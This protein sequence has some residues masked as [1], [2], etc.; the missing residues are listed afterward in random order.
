MPSIHGLATGRY[1]QR[2]KF[3]EDGLHSTLG[4]TEKFRAADAGE[5]PAHALENRLA[6]HV[7]G[8]LF[9]RAVTVTIALDG[10]TFAVTFDDQ[11][12]LKSPN[13]PLGRHAI[14]SVR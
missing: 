11:V 12:H 1:L 3:L 9:E 10:Q 13:S 6:V 4:V 7:F 14:S 2:L 8:E 5:D